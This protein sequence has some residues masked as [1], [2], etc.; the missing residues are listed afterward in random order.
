MAGHSQNRMSPEPKIRCP[1]CNRKGLG[2][3]VWA[4]P[5]GKNPIC[6]RQ[7]RYCHYRRP[8]VVS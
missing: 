8:V 7:C 2:K 6:Y 5:P 3:E 1:K 4:T